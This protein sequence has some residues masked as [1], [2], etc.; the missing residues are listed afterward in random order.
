M[1]EF[2][3]INECYGLNLEKGMR[4]S[5]SDKW[6]EKQGTV[7]GADGCYVKIGWD[8]EKHTLYYPPLSDGLEYQEP[9]III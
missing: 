8:G 2:E 5:Y 1:N 3:Y 6:C 9:G 7:Y 4:V